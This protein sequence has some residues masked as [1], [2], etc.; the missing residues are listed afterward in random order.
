L[1]VAL[2]GPLAELLDVSLKNDPEIALAFHAQPAAVATLIE[3]V[4][5]RSVSW[6]SL[7]DTE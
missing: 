6:T 5:G 4:A 2:P 1:K 3:N 7:G